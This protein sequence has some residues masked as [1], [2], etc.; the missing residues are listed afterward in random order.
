MIVAGITR[1]SEAKLRVMS[2]PASLRGKCGVVT[3]ASLF[4]GRWRR[5]FS[6]SRAREA[7][8]LGIWWASG[9]CPGEE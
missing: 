1:H 2:M 4:S 8:I 3:V 6:A 5:L 7:L 9:G